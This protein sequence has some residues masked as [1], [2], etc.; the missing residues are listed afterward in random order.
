MNWKST[1]LLDDTG[2]KLLA[3]LQANARLS[4]TELGNRVGLS[5]PAVTERIRKLE[6][7]GIITGYHARVDFEKIGLPI[8]ALVNIKELGWER[9]EEKMD[10]I[11]RMP[12]VVEIYRTTG[13]DSMII[14]VVAPAM[15]QLNSIV[16]RLS[17][18]GTPTMSLV[19]G[20]PF[21]KNGKEL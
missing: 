11:E 10:Q 21:I 8:T 19:R 3:E 5:T 17:K 14:K 9:T 1:N 12:E 18:L 2:L 6:D 15:D 13:D 16:C 20:K 4:Y 7:A